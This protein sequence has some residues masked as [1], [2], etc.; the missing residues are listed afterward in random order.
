MS[1]IGPWGQLSRAKGNFPARPRRISHFFGILGGLTLFAE[2]LGNA[3]GT[4]TSSEKLFF[5][6]KA[7][8]GWRKGEEA[9]G[10][11]SRGFSLSSS[12]PP[13]LGVKNG[14]EKNTDQP[15][16]G[17]AE[18]AGRRRGDQ[19]GQGA[20]R[21]GRDEGRRS[22]S[23]PGGVGASKAWRFWVLGGERRGRRGR[24]GGPGAAPCPLPH[25]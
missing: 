20:A 25:R 17:P 18:P 3:A 7:Y 14:P 13:S 10:R 23:A 1:E 4:K 12:L 5:F 16:T 6:S 8:F 19:K 21:L 11:C 15:N 22:R 2:K 24:S 9:T